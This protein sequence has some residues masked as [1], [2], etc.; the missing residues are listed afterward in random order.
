MVATRN[1]RRENGSEA[2]AANPL[3]SFTNSGGWGSIEKSPLT[4]MVTKCSENARAE[5]LQKFLQACSALNPTHT[6]SNRARIEISGLPLRHLIGGQPSIP[7][8][9]DLT[10]RLPRRYAS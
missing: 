8:G 4:R 6:N 7:T 10:S 9:Q 5:F 1:T 2:E 3:I